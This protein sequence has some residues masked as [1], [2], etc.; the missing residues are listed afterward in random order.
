MI[1]ASQSMEMAEIKGNIRNSFEDEASILETEIKLDE[2]KGVVSERKQEELA[3]INVKAKTL[4]QENARDLQR[5]NEEIEESF[6]NKDDKEQ[7]DKKEESG[8]TNLDETE[9]GG[10]ENGNF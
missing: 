5:A 7:V 2:A 9:E 10:T 4:G 3:D 8:F 1:S 6:R